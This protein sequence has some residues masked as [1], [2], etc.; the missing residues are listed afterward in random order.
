VSDLAARPVPELTPGPRR[1]PRLTVV[2][3]PVT[4]PARAPFVLLVL[5]LLGGGLVG[6]LMLN[7]LLAQ[8]AFVLHDLQAQTAA[9]ADREQAL[10]QEV[11]LAASPQ[12]LAA[13]AGALGMVPSGNPAFLRADGTVLGVAKPGVA[14]GLI[15]VPVM[16]GGVAGDPPKPRAGEPAGARARAKA[17]AAK[18]AKAVKA[19]AGR[20]KQGRDGR[21]A[22]REA[23]D[24]NPAGED[25]ERVRPGRRGGGG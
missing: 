23:R 10:Q 7:T 16:P 25:F 9:L 19:E 1:G 20:G 15:G 3:G 24:R 12:R 8:D 17:K 13:V 14:D 21:G 6:L 22:N 5:T 18:K 11:A 4:R 2:A